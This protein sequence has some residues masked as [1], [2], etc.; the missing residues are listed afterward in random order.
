MN[1]TSYLSPFS[2]YCYVYFFRLLNVE[3]ME[4]NDPLEL[5][6]AVKMGGIFTK[7]VQEPFSLSNSYNYLINGFAINRTMT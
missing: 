5:S 3:E 7:E 1:F 6:A 4:F 2:I